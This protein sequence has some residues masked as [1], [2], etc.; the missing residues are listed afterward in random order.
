MSDLLLRV[1]LELSFAP[2]QILK[3]QQIV[4]DLFKSAF[5]PA[6]RVEASLS[7]KRRKLNQAVPTLESLFARE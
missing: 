6:N 1:G 5:C 3:E 4:N 2:P 7:N